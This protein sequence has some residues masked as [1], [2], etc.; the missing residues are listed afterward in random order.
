MLGHSLRSK[1]RRC[2]GL[3]R[4]LVWTESYVA[5]DAINGA[6]RLDYHPWSMAQQFPS[7]GCHQLDHGSFDMLL[8]GFFVF[9]EPS[10][11]VMTLQLAQKAQGLR[12]ESRK[13]R[14][15]A[16]SLA[17]VVICL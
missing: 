10:T 15:H 3:V 2:V 9:Q 8:V 4:P 16:A 6:R 1:Y 12:W 7:Q 13:R 5:I 14:F 17:T 11:I